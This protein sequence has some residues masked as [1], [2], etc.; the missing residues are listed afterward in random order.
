MPDTSILPQ[1]NLPRN[2][3]NPGRPGHPQELHDAP[4]ALLLDLSKQI[5]LQA[6]YWRRMRR[7]VK[8]E[9]NRRQAGRVTS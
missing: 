1:P 8:R 2:A 4:E 7:K 6:D 3:R 9:L 5:E